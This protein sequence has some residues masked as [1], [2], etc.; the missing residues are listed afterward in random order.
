MESR[1]LLNISETW[2]LCLKVLMCMWALIF[3]C[4]NLEQ[5]HIP[6]KLFSWLVFRSVLSFVKTIVF[7]CLAFGV[8]YHL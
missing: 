8:R 6:R 1:F 4:L 7:D 3:R 5:T 2:T